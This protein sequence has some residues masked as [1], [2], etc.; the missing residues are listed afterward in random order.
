VVVELVSPLSG[1]IGCLFINKADCVAKGVGD[2]EQTLTPWH[3]L[4]I[5]AA[6]IATGLFNALIDCIEAIN[7]EVDVLKGVGLPAIRGSGAFGF[8]VP[9]TVRTIS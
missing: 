5:F 9:A 4:N 7:G 1:D 6:Q 2:I 8:V 3:R